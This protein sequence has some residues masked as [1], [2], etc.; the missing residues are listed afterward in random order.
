MR[1]TLGLLLALFTTATALPAQQA[2]S[3]LLSVHR[4][5]G[6]REFR[7]QSFGPAKWL[8]DGSSYTTLEGSEAESGQNLVRYDSERGAREVLV[9]A[10]QFIPQGDSVPLGVEDYSWSPD[11]KL[12]LIFTNTK[13]VWR[14]NTRGD[15]WLLDRTSGRLRKLG[16][17]EAKPST[18]MFAKFS[19]D[20]RRVGY[21]RENNL[22]VLVRSLP[23]RRMGPGLSST[24]HS[25][26]CTKKS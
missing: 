12:L 17:R 4:I 14:L 19:P 20:G 8:G 11:L 22:Y 10:R 18:L 25:T 7:S 24:G 23:S 3:S 16:G 5:Y 2:D 13:P 26:G 6:T 15:Y 9:A 21:V 1:L